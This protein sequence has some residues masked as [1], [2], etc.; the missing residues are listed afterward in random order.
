[1]KLTMKKTNKVLIIDDDPDVRR[2]LQKIL[3][4][5]GLKSFCANNGEM[6]LEILSHEVKPSLIFCDIMMPKMNG[7]EFLSVLKSN[8]DNNLSRIPVVILSSEK[9]MSQEV[10]L[11]G[12]EFLNKSFNA[13][14]IV[15]VV[16][17]YCHLN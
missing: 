1:M 10:A 11:Y 2:A 9:I 13:E 8:H 16:S 14:D 6:A 12:A 7:L 15:S 3:S 5:L 4:I 17:R